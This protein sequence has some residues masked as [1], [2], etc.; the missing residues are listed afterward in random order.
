MLQFVLS[1]FT[2]VAVFILLA[3]INTIQIISSVIE[4]FP[5]DLI[6]STQQGKVMINQP[7]PYKIPFPE[8]G[9]TDN[10]LQAKNIVVFE[11]DGA[12]KSVQDI[13]DRSTLFAI[14]ETS[15]YM[16]KKSN[17][18]SVSAVPNVGEKLELTQDT[19]RTF[20]QRVMNHTFI[21]Y[22]LYV[23]LITAIVVP[24]VLTYV[25]LMR[26]FVLIFLSFVS[27]I[28]AK[29]FLKNGL[30]YAAVYRL[31]M[32]SITPALLA[33]TILGYVY[34]FDM[35]GWFFA[36]AYLV[37]TFICLKAVAKKPVSLRKK[38]S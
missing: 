24:F 33:S 4:L 21:K 19:L 10:P 31:S 1:L 6:V 15:F 5:A 29:I 35:Q 22:K 2:V 20:G 12:I 23:P 34:K 26:F 7:L 18:M 16:L 14:T 30:S 8:Y 11:K 36:L 17:E 9:N 13:H 25:L 3:R 37:W 38:K 32:H 28:I 27:W